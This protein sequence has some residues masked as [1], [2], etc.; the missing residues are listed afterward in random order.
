LIKNELGVQK[1]S[2]TPNHDPV[3]QLSLDQVKKIARMKFDSLLSNNMNTAV[4]EI[5]GT[6][7]SIGV[8]IDGKMAKQ[9][10]K[11]VKSGKYE[12]ELVDEVTQ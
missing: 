4:R 1:G 11:E 12:R 2:G 5:A 9:F 8:K 10:I 7:H 6:C 3:G